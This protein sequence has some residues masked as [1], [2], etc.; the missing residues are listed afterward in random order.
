MNYIHRQTIEVK[1]NNWN[2]ILAV[3]TDIQQ[4]QELMTNI[5][6]MDSLIYKKAKKKII[7]KF[8]CSK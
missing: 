8:I 1:F 7:F 4:I 3:L 6:Y 5:L 2:S